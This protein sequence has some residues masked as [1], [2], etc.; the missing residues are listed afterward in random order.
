MM[1]TRTE[2]NDF[3]P[4]GKF[5]PDATDEAVLEGFSKFL[6][7][8]N[9]EAACCGYLGAACE[10]AMQRPHL[11]V[12]LLPTVVHPAYCMGVESAESFIAYA[13][14]LIERDAALDPKYQNFSRDGAKYFH[15]FMNCH[16]AEIQRLLDQWVKKELGH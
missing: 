4:K 8:Y 9:A 14:T 5:G 16:S 15:Q 10:I 11:F 12:S 2:L 1:K 7:S 3:L 6:V 13:L